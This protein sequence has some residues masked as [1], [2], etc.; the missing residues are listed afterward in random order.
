MYKLHLEC[1]ARSRWFFAW[2]PT[3][4]CYKQTKFQETFERNPMGVSLSIR[5]GYDIQAGSKGL[6]TTV[7]GLRKVAGASEKNGQG[8]N[9]LSK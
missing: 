5:G 6:E 4:Q 3:W 1:A 8:P 7:S 2:G 9:E